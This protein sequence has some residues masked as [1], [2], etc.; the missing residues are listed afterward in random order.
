MPVTQGTHWSGPTMPDR[1]EVTVAPL[2][3]S[4][5]TSVP[6]LKDVQVDTHT[7]AVV[8]SDVGSQPL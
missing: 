8:A 7:V 4:V 3:S 1:A 2:T 6:T 5:Y